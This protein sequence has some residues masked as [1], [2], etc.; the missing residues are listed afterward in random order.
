MYEEK[1]SERLS[2]LRMKKAVSAREMSLALGQNS[3]YINHIENGQTFP[4]LIAFFNICEYL[5]VT[6]HDFFD[7]D[8]PAPAEE[9]EITAKLK[10]LNEKE[11]ES[12][13][14]IIESLAK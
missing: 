7:Y 6:P 9:K 1:F 8:D 14:T 5:S 13:R 11:L 3:G 2:E 12:I 4:S 10:K